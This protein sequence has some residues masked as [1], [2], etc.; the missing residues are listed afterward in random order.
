MRE[1][2]NT[3][4]NK[5]SRLAVAAAFAPLAVALAFLTFLCVRA[6]SIKNAVPT[7]LSQS[8]N[9]QLQ[10][11]LDALYPER[12]QT[13]NAL[14][15]NIVP[16]SFELSAK[17][18]ILINAS[19]GEI[20]FEKNADQE[21][22]PAS[23]IKLFLIYSVLQK[24]RA[25]AAN[26]DDII[27]IDERAIAANMPPRSSLMFLGKGQ[28]VTLRELLQG[29]SVASGND[30]A[31]QIA[32]SL[33]GSMENFLAEINSIIKNAGLQ[34]THI[35]EPSGYSEENITTPREMATFCKI[36]LEEFPDALRE[37]HSIKEFEYPKQK[38]LPPQQQNRAQQNFANNIP[39]EIWTTFHLKNTNTL[40]N[41]LEGCDGIKTG[42]IDESGYNLALTT[43]RGGVRYISVTMLGPG[44]T[45]QKGDQ[46]RCA[47]GTALHE[48]AHANFTQAPLPAQTEF[49]LP[50]YG[51]Q[52]KA[53][54]LCAAFQNARAV[55][56]STNIEYKV[57]LPNYVFGKIQRGAPYGQI[58][59]YSNGAPL[60]GIPLVAE[61]EI[62]AA[63]G[64]IQKCDALILNLSKK[65]VIF[66]CQNLL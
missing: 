1:N 57:E 17:A 61:R 2:Q 19:T 8:E 23:M 44:E 30:A 66:F 53:V 26:L 65:T 39:K 18:A 24:V 10:D 7:P 32:F 9:A 60:F 3:A 50:L 20:L 27:P 52:K 48:W 40:L 13:L 49:S 37:F 63:N 41:T 14:H 45:M 31:H 47:D 5:K 51:A 43:T 12:T 64:F 42:H 38:N 21:I 6:N 58:V 28:I 59:L 25:G 33:Y 16:P 22:P 11:A 4:Q 29:L 36:Y 46:L 62:P 15:Y 56:K 54:M 35:V 34:K 55:P